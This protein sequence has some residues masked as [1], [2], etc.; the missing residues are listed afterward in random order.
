M[1]RKGLYSRLAS[2]STL[3]M[4]GNDS[5]GLELLGTVMTFVKVFV[6]TTVFNFVGYLIAFSYGRTMASQFGAASGFA[7][8]CFICLI[9][10]MRTLFFSYVLIF[11]IFLCF[12]I[13]IVSICCYHDARKRW[14]HLTPDE[15]HVAY[16]PCSLHDC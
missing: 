9:V 11:P 12:V 6:F 7:L 15:R 5:N 8:S 1:V 14:P 10:I 4:A 13:F 2:E 3:H 16:P